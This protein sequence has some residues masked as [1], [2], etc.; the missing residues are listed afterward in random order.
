VHELAID[1]C[2][3]FTVYTDTKFGIFGDFCQF[4]FVSELQILVDISSRFSWP[5]P[6]GTRLFEGCFGTIAMT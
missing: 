3:I 6:L 1:P 2:S 5:N 4:K